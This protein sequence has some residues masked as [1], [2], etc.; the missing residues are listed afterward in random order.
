MKSQSYEIQSRPDE[1]AVHGENPQAVHIMNGFLL[2]P[3]RPYRPAGET[4]RAPGPEVIETTTT[5][6]C[7]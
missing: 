6:D 4:F 2:P 5:L 7:S 1:Q 3:N